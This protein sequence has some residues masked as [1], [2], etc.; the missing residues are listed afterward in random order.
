MHVWRVGLATRNAVSPLV[1]VLL[2]VTENHVKEVS[3]FL[4]MKKGKFGGKPKT[5]TYSKKSQV[6]T[7]CP[8][9][10]QVP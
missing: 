6:V 9:Y 3:F 4:N 7:V 10:L 2:G 1:T 5:T 8:E